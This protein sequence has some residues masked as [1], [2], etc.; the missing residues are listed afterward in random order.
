[1]D[2]ETDIHNAYNLTVINGQTQQFMVWA[3]LQYFFFFL[4][5]P[6]HYIHS[7]LDRYTSVLASIK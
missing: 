3:F 7:N 6:P 5:G 2:V 4:L 1:M